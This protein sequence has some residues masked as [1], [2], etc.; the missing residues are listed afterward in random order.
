MPHPTPAPKAT[1]RSR[2][3]VVRLQ[4][5]HAS[6]LLVAFFIGW[7]TL[8]GDLWLGDKLYAL[9]GQS[10]SLR[11][12]WF[13]QNVVHQLGREISI[14]AWLIVLAAWL[15]A[16]FRSSAQHLR[17]P[18]LYLLVAV[19]LSTLLVSWTKSWSNVDCP[20]DLARYGGT[21]TYFG[22]FEAKSAGLARGVCFPA[23]HA[24]GGYAWM[25]LYFFLWM[26]RPQW[27][28]WGLAVGVGA[29]LLFGVAQQLRGAHFLSHDIAAAAIC[30]TST[31]IT[32]RLLGARVAQ[33]AQVPPAPT[34]APQPS[35][36]SVPSTTLPS[37]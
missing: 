13:T 35:L 23:G 37:P 31:V 30:W 9:E 3:R 2:N 15:V 5:L 36:P 6:L 1:P 14:A 28:W 16:R 10:W 29:G 18:L 21:R 32:Y 12:A 22:L 4:G 26:V 8:H 24:S 34:A 20:W 25:A 19:A 17:R 7:T 33:P 11:H 27:R